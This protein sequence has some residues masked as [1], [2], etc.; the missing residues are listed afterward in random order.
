MGP[1]V[2]RCTMLAMYQHETGILAHNRFTFR[3]LS[4]WP[5]H[6]P[7]LCGMH[8]KPLLIQQGLQTRNTFML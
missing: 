5:A 3:A 7:S 8:G 2:S 1:P 4:Q 6:G